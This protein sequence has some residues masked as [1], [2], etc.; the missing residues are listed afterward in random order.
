MRS[1]L[2]DEVE[3]HYKLRMP[4]DFYHFWDFCRCL[5][6][7]NPRG[8]VTVY[9]TKKPVNTLTFFIEYMLTQLPYIDF[10]V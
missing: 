5:Q 2:R 1:E 9:K 7:D 8:K 6:P 10:R 3:Q 4:E